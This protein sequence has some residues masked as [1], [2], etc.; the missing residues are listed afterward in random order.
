MTIEQIVTKELE[1]F[2]DNVSRLKKSR[3]AKDLR[4]FIS[5]NS[6]FWGIEKSNLETLYVLVGI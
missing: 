4:K 2:V 1:I 5:A 6:D 3:H